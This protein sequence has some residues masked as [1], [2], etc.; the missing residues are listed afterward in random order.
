PNLCAVVSLSQ[1]QTSRPPLHRV[2]PLAQGAPGAPA[3]AART[4]LPSHETRPASASCAA[5]THCRESLPST[6]GLRFE[7]ASRSYAFQLQCGARWN[8][9]SSCSLHECPGSGFGG[10]SFALRYI[11]SSSDSKTLPSYENRVPASAGG[12]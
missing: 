3:R 8:E 5:S 6:P 9:V 7:I 4:H 12:Q 11:T 2:Q 10:Q 1:A